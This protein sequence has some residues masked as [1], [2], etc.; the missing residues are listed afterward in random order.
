MTAQSPR[1]NTQFVDARAEAGKRAVAEPE[2]DGPD[3]E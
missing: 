1:T 3:E 2:T